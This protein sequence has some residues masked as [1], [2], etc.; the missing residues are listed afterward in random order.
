MSFFNSERKTGTLFGSTTAPPGGLFANSQNQNQNQNQNQQQQN[1][2]FASLGQS[3][4]NTQQ[5]QQPN[6][7]ASVMGGIVRPTPQLHPNHAQQLQQQQQALP[8]LRQS[9][10]DKFTTSHLDG[11]RKHISLSLQ[12]S[13]T[14]RRG[15]VHR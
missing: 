13:L 8:K 14:C 9:T 12:A 15:E 6:P 4:Q 2:L 5:Q 11:T 10:N 3:Q 1:G 7:G